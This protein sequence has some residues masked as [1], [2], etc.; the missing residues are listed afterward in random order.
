MV[1]R[2]LL[3]SLS[4]LVLCG[5]GATICVAGGPPAG[6]N[7]PPMVPGPPPICGPVESSYK[8]ERIQTAP[9]PAQLRRVRVVA[10]YLSGIAW[11]NKPLAFVGNPQTF[12][13]PIAPGRYEWLVPVGEV[14]FC[15]DNRCVWV[16]ANYTKVPCGPMA[17]GMMPIAA[18]PVMAPKV[19]K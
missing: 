12:P 2:L 6:Y 16:K 3:L 11:P 17:G 1:K 15:H 18:P 10:P 19:C 5:A 14:N 4:V 7:C 9:V 13:N 8:L